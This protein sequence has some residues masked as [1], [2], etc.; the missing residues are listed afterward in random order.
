MD[1]NLREHIISSVI[2]NL[3]YILKYAGAQAVSPVQPNQSFLE[4]GTSTLFSKSSPGEPLVQL[5]LSLCP[6]IFVA[7][8]VAAVLIFLTKSWRS[9]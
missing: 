2:M 6:R 4:W 1:F 5:R 9:F 3:D 7:S 8:V